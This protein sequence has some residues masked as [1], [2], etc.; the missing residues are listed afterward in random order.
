MNN[1]SEAI[2]LHERVTAD[3]KKE[4]D[5][6]TYKV[7]D[8]LPS[9]NE[10]CASYNTT[11]P[12]VRHALLRL[13]NMGYIVRHKGKGSIVAEPKRALGILS[14]SGV[15]AGVG[16]E[17]LKT[18]I[19]QKPAAVPWPIALLPDVNEIELAAGCIYFTRLRIISD[20][21]V[22]FEETFIS[23]L[24]MKGLLKCNLEN[25]SL[26]KTLNDRFNIE[27]RGG[28]QSFWAKKADKKISDLL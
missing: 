2:P 5:N 14:V 27:V 18:A 4:I 7:G 16:A 9:E 15:T 20:K 23:N 12:T 26:F 1:R 17:K 24:D 3:L 6:G 21:P 11:R 10:L 22:L 8:L 13:I 28:M 19:L 25:R